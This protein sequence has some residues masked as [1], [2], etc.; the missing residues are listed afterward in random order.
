VKLLERETTD[1]ILRAFFDVYNELGFRFL[2]AVYQRALAHRR[3]VLGADIQMEVGIS[4][5]FDDVIVGTYRADLI[6]DSVVLVEIKRG[7]RISNDHH[8]QLL[9]YLKSTRI[10]VG[11]LLNFG[12]R[13]EFKRLALTRDSKDSRG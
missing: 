6:V 13:P 10:E 7:R 2:E 11:L 1:R 9:H 5:L 12:E 4:V 3:R 8:A